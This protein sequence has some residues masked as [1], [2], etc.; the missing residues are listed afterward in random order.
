MYNYYIGWGVLLCIIVVNFIVYF[1]IKHKKD[2]QLQSQS[3][4][5]D[6]EF[7]QS[8]EFIQNIRGTVLNQ[9]LN[10]HTKLF[11]AIAKQK[12]ILNDQNRA[13][14]AIFITPQ[15]FKELINVNNTN[16]PEQI[17]QLYGAIKGLEIP[18]GFLGDLPIY[19]S[20]LLINAP[21]FVVGSI[22]WSFDK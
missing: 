8:Q 19:I 2:K 14:I 6:S 17:D 13:A 20:E 12:Q 16:S 18:V 9:L 11:S 4:S 15:I 7:K 21:V 3:Q 5:A 22:T 10:N 1:R